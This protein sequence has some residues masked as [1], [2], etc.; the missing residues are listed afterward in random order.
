M[1]N[2]LLKLLGSKVSGSSAKPLYDVTMERALLP[3]LYESGLADD[4]FD[5]R[6]ETVA[7]HSA[8]LM[9]SL[10]CHE[11]PGRQLADELY[12][13]VFQGFDHALR[14]RGAGDSSIARKVRGLG[15][16]FFGLARAIDTALGSEDPRSELR[17]VLVRNAIGGGNPDDLAQYLLQIDSSLRDVSLEAFQSGELSLPEIQ[18]N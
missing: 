17:S 3:A 16:R 4:T 13:L 1:P 10:R 14:E 18:G 9:R 15:E 8:L 7:L 2:W 5:G 12:K 6:F 11:E